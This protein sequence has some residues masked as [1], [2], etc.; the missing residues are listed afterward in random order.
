[1]TH[2]DAATLRP[3]LDAFRPLLDEPDPDIEMEGDKSIA[4]DISI[5]EGSQPGIRARLQTPNGKI[6][7]S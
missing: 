1:M 5:R 3:I 7:L 2:P 6:D 4:A